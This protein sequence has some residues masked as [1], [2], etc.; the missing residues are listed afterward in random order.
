[1][2]NVTKKVKEYG[3]KAM[4]YLKDEIGFSGRNRKKKIDKEVES[5]TDLPSKRKSNVKVGPME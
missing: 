2:D 4:E 5:V 1:M 3:D